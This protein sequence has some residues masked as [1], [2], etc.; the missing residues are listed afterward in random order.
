MHR[1][2]KR[3]PQA[4]ESGQTLILFTLF[5]IVLILFVGLGIDL[6]FAY[7]TRAQLS[8]AVDAACLTGIRNYNSDHVHG[9][10]CEGSRR[11]YISRQL[12]HIREGRWPCHP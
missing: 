7:I 5:I 9:T 10:T 4:R 11:Q 8:K 2:L 6:G 3:K 12:W 1:S